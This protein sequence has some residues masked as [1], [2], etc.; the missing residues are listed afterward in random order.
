[1]EGM[2]ES[3]W[4]L[5]IAE[6]S[7][8]KAGTIILCVIIIVLSLL[9]FWKW[10]YSVY[11][12][13]KA[14]IAKKKEDEKKADEELRSNIKK[15][16]D[17]LPELDKQVLNLSTEFSSLKQDWVKT[18]NDLNQ[19]I[20]TLQFDIQES[21]KKN[22]E[23][24][25]EMSEKLNATQSMINSMQTTTDKIVSDIGVLF[26]GENNEFR[27]YIT[28]LHAKH[29]ENGEPMTRSIRQELRIKFESYDN[30]G[31]NG[32]AKQLYEELMSLPIAHEFHEEL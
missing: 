26:D 6:L 12:E 25:K 28:Q 11:K 24:D 27:I 21:T 14:E 2:T 29:V 7:K 9:P 1:M 20:D 8:T 10:I 30:R 31:G 4:D 22:E 13:K 5:V 19:K 18:S 23:S 15:I 16:S 3:S 32:W 17:H